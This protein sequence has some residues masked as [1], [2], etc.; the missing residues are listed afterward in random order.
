MKSWY[1]LLLKV[2]VYETLWSTVILQKLLVCQP[3]KQLLAVFEPQRFMNVITRGH[4]KILFWDMRVALIVTPCFIKINFNIKISWNVNLYGA[5]VNYHLFRWTYWGRHPGDEGSKFFWHVHSYLWKCMALHPRRQYSNSYS[6]WC[7]NLTCHNCNSSFRLCA[8]G[9]FPSLPTWNFIYIP[10]YHPALPLLY[11][12]Y[13]MNSTA[14]IIIISSSNKGDWDNFK[15][16]RAVYQKST[17]LRKYKKGHTYYR[18][19]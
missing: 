5:I 15:I 9:L 14:I 7:K 10:I 18:K 1:C 3:A 11:G 13:I 12:H 2:L 6:H 16:T 19:Y 17:K 8:C 4:S